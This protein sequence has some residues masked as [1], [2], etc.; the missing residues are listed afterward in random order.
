MYT[1][2]KVKNNLSRSDMM[3]VLEV[4]MMK[5]LL[6]TQSLKFQTNKHLLFLTNS[7]LCKEKRLIMQRR[8]G[9]KK[10]QSFCSGQS[11]NTAEERK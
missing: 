9:P 7:I 5:C 11:I 3:K 8:T 6:L 10:K 2:L 4:M 1:F